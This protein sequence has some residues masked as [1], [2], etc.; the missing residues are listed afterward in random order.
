MNDVLRQYL[1]IFYNVYL[2]D[3]LIYSQTRGEYT[4]HI[5]LVL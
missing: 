2:D 4:E 5:R 3:I 1:D